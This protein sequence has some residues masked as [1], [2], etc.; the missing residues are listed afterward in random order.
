MAGALVCSAAQTPRPSPE[1]TINM[2]EGKQTLLSSYRGKPTVVVFILTYC[3]HCQKTVGILTK[4]HREYAPR[5]LNVIAVAVEDMAAM[6]V[7]GFIKQFQPS[8]PVGFAFRDQVVEY[9][10]H[11]PQ[12]VM[13]MPQLVFLDKGFNIREQHGGD[14]QAFF[15]NQE[16]SIRRAIETLLNGPTAAHPAAKKPA[17]PQRK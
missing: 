8:F 4:L 12:L 15:E 11:P 13:L 9:L 10:Q 6:A 16:A 5:G 17:S 2:G 3:S 1:F 14:D 7:P